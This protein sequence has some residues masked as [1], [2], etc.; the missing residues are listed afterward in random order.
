MKDRILKFRAWDKF[1]DQYWY[2]DKYKNLA[3][4]F[5]VIQGFIDGGNEIILERFTG[6]KDNNGVE[7]YEGD[8]EKC[9]SGLHGVVKYVDELA[10][11]TL[12]IIGNDY[13][14]TVYSKQIDGKNIMREVV[15]N[16]HKNPELL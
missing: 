4:F 12:E 2:S 13:E 8:I 7:I 9:M 14:A 16:I 3:D 10:L 1:N 15:G 11:F 6:L 5:C